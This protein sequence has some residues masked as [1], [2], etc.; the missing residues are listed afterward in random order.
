MNHKELERWYRLRNIKRASQLMIVLC[1]VLAV[2]GY[3]VS[4][5]LIRPDPS[6]SDSFIPSDAGIRI[7]NFSYSVPGPRPWELRAPSA[8]VSESLD[9]VT[10]QEPRIIYHAGPGGRISLASQTGSLHKKTLSVVA[11]GEVTLTYKD[12]IFRSDE[13]NYSHEKLS[14]STS[15]S[16]FFETPDL[17]L[18]GT[19]MT[20]NLENEEI[21]IEN[22]VKARLFNLKWVESKGRLPM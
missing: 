20:M 5:W 11:R 12:Y 21:V 16:V 9:E 15:S 6:Q 3:V 4:A 1:S 8:I 7:E 18:T 19:G 2:S 22:D 10:L 14:A 17:S 13:M